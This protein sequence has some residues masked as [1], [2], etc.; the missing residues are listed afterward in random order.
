MNYQ[1]DADGLIIMGTTR[2]LPD[3]KGLIDAAIAMGE[4]EGK[5]HDF[6]ADGTIIIFCE[7]E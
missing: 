6:D 7:D 4:I 5:F 2:E 3:L 1:I